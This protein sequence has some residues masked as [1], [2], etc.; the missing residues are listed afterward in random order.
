MQNLLKNNPIARNAEAH[1]KMGADSAISGRYRVANAPWQAEILRALADPS[2]REVTARLAAQMGKNVIAELF[3]GYVINHAPGNML[4][5]GQTDDD[6]ELFAKDRLFKRLSELD[7]IAP[8]W[9]FE[10]GKFPKSGELMLPHMYI[11]AQGANPSNL[12]GK[13]ARYLI[14]DEVHLWKPGMLDNARDRASAFWDAKIFNISTAGEED[15]DENFAFMAG[16]QETWHIGCPEC[17]KLVRLMWGNGKERVVKWE[18]NEKTKPEGKVWNFQELR[19]TIVF[20][21]PHCKCEEK[22]SLQTRIHMNEIGGYVAQNDSANIDKR[23][24]HASQLAAPW[25]PWEEIVERWIKAI[26][27]LKTGDVE[28]LKNFVIKRLAETWENQTPGGTQ[29]VITGGYSMRDEF[30]WQDESQR[31]LSVDV[32]EKGGRHFWGLV[33]AFAQDGRSKL[34]APA[35]LNT[36]ADINVMAKDYRVLPSRVIVDARFATT[37]V[38]EACALYGW[39]W[40]QADENARQYG[41]RIPETGSTIFRPYSTPRTRD[42]GIGTK[43]AGRRLAYGI[44]F[45]KDWARELLHR[46]IMGLGTEWGLPD[47]IADLSW[48]GTNT[49]KTTY[50][51][52]LNSWINAEKTDPQ[53]NKPRRFWKKINRDDHLRACEEMQ[54]V[55]AAMQGLIPSDLSEDDETSTS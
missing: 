49:K 54:L 11:L 16:T 23:S 28:L 19:K 36:W 37:E 14:N 5:N 46:R 4:V 24:F 51:E 52:Q 1:V 10:R 31:F 8:V 43:T 12:Q 25:V 9:P 15:S 22:D 29:A 32:Q 38:L 6:A 27:R 2:I 17:K 47:D 40:M 13:S 3:A 39:T 35:R 45:S 50:L 21:C 55:A 20:K 30:Q 48:K 33:R 42:P 41:H 18:S 34:V 53:T 44:N 26:E 7:S